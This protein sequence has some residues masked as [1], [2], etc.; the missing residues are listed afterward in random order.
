MEGQNIDYHGRLQEEIMNRYRTS[1]KIYKFVSVFHVAKIVACLMP[2]FLN[3]N[4]CD[5]FESWLVWYGFITICMNIKYKMRTR[6]DPLNGNSARNLKCYES[7]LMIMDLFWFIIGWNTLGLNESCQPLRAIIY[8]LLM[9]DLSV[10]IIM[11]IISLLLCC[12]VC[13]RLCL[14]MPLVYWATVN[15]S[16][17]HG[18]R[19][20]DIA[21]LPTST[22]DQQL[23]NQVACPICLEDFTS[24][25]EIRRFPCNHIF[26]KD[27]IDNWLR[28]N[29]TCPMC[30]MSITGVPAPVTESGQQPAPQINQNYE[31]IV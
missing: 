4:G 8:S 14:N 29:I 5:S 6:V 15:M 20:E 10:S 22:F 28:L 13:R 2:L 19:N 17:Q 12:M 21:T 31:S 11:L 9:F 27:C 18:L 16:E 30:R 24:G 26:H 25:Q 1:N 3:I 23:H 7:A